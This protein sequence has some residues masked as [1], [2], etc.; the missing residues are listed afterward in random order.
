MAAESLRTLIISSLLNDGESK[1]FAVLEQKKEQASIPLPEG[2]SS[3]SSS[4]F[5]AGQVIPLN[6]DLVF[7]IYELSLTNIAGFLSLL[8]PFI[9]Y[10]F[11]TNIFKQLQRQKD[12]PYSLY[13]FFIL[14]IAFRCCWDR[15][16]YIE[17]LPPASNSL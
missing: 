11:S 3:S 12:C 7:H 5:Y 6:S 10:A 13:D 1:L 15:L 2:N 8:L 16:P 14:A 9:D 17:I 4:S